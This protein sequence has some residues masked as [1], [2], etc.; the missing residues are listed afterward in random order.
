MVIEAAAANREAENIRY[1]RAYIDFFEDQ[2]VRYGYDWRK[3]LHDYL[4]EGEQPLINCVVAGR[5]CTPIHTS[6]NARRKLD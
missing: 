2:L 6:Y 3:L 1:Q 4:F 5:T